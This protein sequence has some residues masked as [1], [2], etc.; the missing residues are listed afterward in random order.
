MQPQIS[1]VTDLSGLYR[2]VAVFLD[3]GKML[4]NGNPSTLAPWLDALNLARGKRVF[5]LGCGTGYYT[6]VIAEVVG[7]GGHV[8]AVEVEPGVAE[9]ARANLA[10]YPHVE[11]LQGDGGAVDPGVQDA[12]LINA[13][14]THPTQGWLDGLAESGTLLFPMTLEFG[15][16]NVGKGLAEHWPASRVLSEPQSQK[17]GCSALELM[18]QNP[19]CMG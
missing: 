12:I 6:A 5:H 4:T 19:V 18:F 11:V 13:G 15:T 2:D 3:A 16:P 8:T 10:H 9:Q 14:V 7:P 1:G 17:Q